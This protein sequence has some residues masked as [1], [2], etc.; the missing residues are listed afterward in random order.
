MTAALQIFWLLVKPKSRGFF[1]LVPTGRK[2]DLLR[3]AFFAVFGL[4]CALGI[5]LLSV[6]FLRGCLSVELVGTLIPRKLMSLTLLI[7][8]SILLMSTT[9]SSFSIFFLSDD[10]SLL[11][12]KPIPWGPLY[13]ARFLEMILHSSWMVVF[14]GLPIFLAYGKVYQGP[15]VYYLAMIGLFIALIL[16]PGAL[17]AMIATLL[18]RMFSARR[19]RDLMIVLVVAGFVLLYLLIRAMK[20]EQLLDQESFGTMM[21]FLRMFRTPGMTFL[22][23][24]WMTDA[25]FPLLE[26]KPLP[27]IMPVAA[28]CSTAAALVVISAWLGAAFYQN[29][30]ARAQEGRLRWLSPAGRDAVQGRIFGPWLDRLAA[31]LGGM[32]GPLL[33]KDIRVFMRDANQW[34][35]LLLLAALAAVYIMNFVYLKAADFSWFVLYT[36]NHV[37]LGL[38]LS[39]IAVRFV[40]P[41]VS[42]EGRAWWIVRTAPVRMRD[43]LHSKLLIHLLPLQA[44][45]VMLSVLSAAVIGV[46]LVFAVFS[47]ALMLAMTLGVCSLGIGIGAMYP[48]FHAENAA[49]IPTGIGGVTYMIVS[50][51]FVLVFLLASVYPSFTL[52]QLPKHLSRPVMRPAWFFASLATLVLLTLIATWLPMFLGRRSLAR[53]AS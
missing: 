36:V 11:I 12:S 50:M 42:L 15:P 18:T 38:V 48:R 24:V 33:A 5:Y 53:R 28:L 1:R 46:P 25:L 10:L 13:F 7:L 21:E 40:F 43:F 39:G 2:R 19:S 20:P 14:F 35:Q 32:T 6:W 30:Y 22:P 26:S 4:G 3:L 9:I 45:A 27:V 29:C 31:R 49:K 44:L 8:L 51:G 16:I 23:S 17:G 41:A 34:L 37:L 47:V 52:Y